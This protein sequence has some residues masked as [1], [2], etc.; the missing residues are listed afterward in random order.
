ARA[1]FPIIPAKHPLRSSFHVTFLIRRSHRLLVHSGSSVSLF[2]PSF[3]PFRL[4]LSLSI[5]TH[6]ISYNTAFHF[7][8]SLLFSQ[9]CRGERV[10]L[11]HLRSMQT[12]ETHPCAVCIV[13]HLP[14]YGAGS[15]GGTTKVLNESAGRV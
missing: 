11:P 8:F 5:S 2:F 1:I 15:A 6:C 7:S 13:A 14:R 10:R 4:H 9:K 12:N 3:P